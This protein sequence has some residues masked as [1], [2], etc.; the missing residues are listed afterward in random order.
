MVDEILNIL[1][2]YL[3]CFS[4]A[5]ISIAF[6][7]D[8]FKNREVR[9]FERIMF[10][11][12]LS[13]F[14]AFYNPIID[15]G[16]KIFEQMTVESD[17]EI[18]LYLERCRTVRFEGDIGFFD[19]FITS[20]QANFCKLVL[21]CNYILRFIS[22]FL[23][24]YF[25]V[26]FKAMV[27]IVSGLAAWQIFR[28]ILW[29]FIT[30]SIAVMMWSVGYQIAD[31]FILKGIA[32]IGIPSAL[33]SGVG[34]MVITGGTAL[35][36]LLVFLI[37]L[38]IGMCIFYILTPIV[39][40]S[41]LSG[42]NPGTAVTSNM[43]TAALASMAGAK[44][45]AQVVYKGVERISKITKSPSTNASRPSSSMSLNSVTQAMRPHK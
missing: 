30:Y 27:P 25:M 40:F 43:R 21:S 32:L 18:D 41:V 23:Q 13:A 15:E 20:L 38:L 2:N 42:A 4:F 16:T 45:A 9:I 31:I 8:C 12:L 36:G 29:K 28:N 14:I 34:A 26:A 3:R 1:I 10:T 7:C 11:A 37:A 5:S 19:D 22:S 44:P 24:V 35:M 33:S 6:M 39:I 17:N